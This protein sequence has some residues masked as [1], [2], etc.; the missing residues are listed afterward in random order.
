MYIHIYIFIKIDSFVL[1]CQRHVYLCNVII[2]KDYG[3]DHHGNAHQQYGGWKDEDPCLISVAGAN[4]YSH[5]SNLCIY[6]YIYIF[7]KIDSFV[8]QCQRHVYLCNVIISKDYGEDHH[9]NA[10]QQYGGWK[11]ED[12]CLISVAG[13]NVYSHTSNLC[14]YIY[15]YLS[16]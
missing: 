9:G 16:R 10:H 1:Q 12:P 15:I 7:I 6:I 5:T 3:E 13:A 11:D 8:L 2:S 4:V 14:I